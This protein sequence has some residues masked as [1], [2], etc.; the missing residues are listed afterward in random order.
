MVVSVVKV[1]DIVNFI[2]YYVDGLCKVGCEVGYKVF[3]CKMCML[4]F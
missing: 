4:L 3:V 1:V 2:C